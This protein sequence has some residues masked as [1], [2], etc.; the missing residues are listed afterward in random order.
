MDFFAN[1]WGGLDH[2]GSIAFWIYLSGWVI[3]L[4]MLFIVP[5]R[6]SPASAQAW[7]LLI[8]IAP[9]LGLLLFSYV[10]SPRLPRWR[11]RRMQEL[12]RLMEPFQPV[13]DQIHGHFAPELEDDDRQVAILASNLT[14]LPPVGGNSVEVLADYKGSIDRL[15]ADIDA[16]RH[17]V[18]L[19]Y[20]IFADDSVGSIVIAALQRAMKRGVECRVLFDSVG[21]KI[22]KRSMHRRLQEAGIP[23]AEFSPVGL[24]DRKA[25]RPDLRNHRKIAVIDGWIG[26]SG[27]QNLVDAQFKEGLVYEE[28]VVRIQGPLVLHLQLVFIADWFVETGEF[29]DPSA[30]TPELQAWGDIAGQVVPSGPSYAARLN[31]RVFL[32]ILHRARSHVTL[33]TPY[34]IPSESL[35]QAIETASLRGVRV[36]LIVPEVMDQPLVGLAQASYFEELLDAGVV[37]RRYPKRFLHSKLLTVDGR[38][39]VVGSSNLDIRSFMLN[40]EINILIYG[41]ESAEYF[42]REQERYLHRSRPLDPEAWR[43]RPRVQQMLENTA[44]LFSA[45]L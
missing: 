28:L 4:V 6:R 32:S 8:V 12:L 10:G 37:I 17:H 36:E 29:V 15:V 14:R 40:N 30:Y 44:R 26:Y 27:S 16:A 41:R 18:H 11:R 39:A 24:F 34:F 22:Y 13:L 20:Y 38:A 2:P 9:W 5:A 25:A 21:S 43:R 19:L 3:C 31:E 45:L 23:H 35:L 33:T 7:L 42:F 1:G